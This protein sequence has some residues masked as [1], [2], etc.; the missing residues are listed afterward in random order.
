MRERL[1]Q[2]LRS[3]RVQLAL[4][5]ALVHAVLMVLF[6]AELVHSQQGFLHERHVQ[7]G[8]SLTQGMAR[9]SVSDLLSRDLAGLQ[10]I[11]EG[12]RTYPEM[13]Y[14][15]IVDMRGKVLA[16]SDPARA[17]SFLTDAVST[18]MLAGPV[19]SGVLVDD[20]EV[21]DVASP[22]QWQGRAIGWVRFAAG[23]EGVNAQLRKVTIEGIGFAGLSVA[24]GVVLAI[25]MSRSTTSRLYEL[26][27]V[28]AATSRGERHARAAADEGHEVGRLAAAFNG[29]LD[30]LASQER[31][32]LKTNEEL[33]R[34]VAQRTA[35]LARSEEAQR[36]ILEQANDAFVAIGVD[37]RVTAWNRAAE[38]MFGYTAA[39]ALGRPMAELIIPPRYREAHARGHSGFI[40]TGAG[41]VVNRR[42]EITGLHRDG[43]EVPIELSVSAIATPD[44]FI[45]NAFM[46]DIRERV[47]AQEAL[48]KSQSRLHQALE[49]LPALV[50][51][52]DRE[53]RCRYGNR[54]GRKL[55]DLAPGEEIGLHLRDAVGEAI[56]R[57]HEPHLPTVLA[58]EPARFEGSAR[59]KGKD[60]HF[61]VHLVPEKDPGDNQL[62]GFYVMTFDVTALKEAQ[63][64]QERARRQLRAITDNLPV[65]ISY[66]DAEH[67]LQFLNR[68][69]EEWTGV[70]VS[71]AL[72]KTLR[73]AVGEQL[74]EQRR[75]ALEQALRGER[76]L[77]EVVSNAL[78]VRRV[79]QTAYI[80]DCPSAE[81]TAGVYTLTSDVTALRDAE[82]KMAELALTDTLTGLANRRHFEQRLP[83]ALSRAARTRKGTAL[84]FLDVDHFKRINDSFGHAAGDAV[85][86]TFAQ[87]L[88]AC[89]RSTD[90]VARLAG[91]EFVVVLEGLNDIDECH[92]IA[93]KV[94]TAARGL[95]R[96]ESQNL[97][98][99]TSIGIAY[100]AGG[101]PCRA[102]VVLRHADEALYRTKERGRDGYTLVETGVEDARFETSAFADL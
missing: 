30:T 25:W 23:M 86:V 22:V 72:G 37:G 49:S 39:Q 67:R 18:R 84:M 81:V 55:R 31:Q 100:L 35:A 85:L 6:V 46:R 57:L 15:A 95:L 10:E 75:S 12:L 77:F 11:V 50:G 17:G 60:V 4:G 62:T 5:V 13:R 7:R 79:L 64:Q 61:H 38:S 69:F 48:K 97:Q 33:E 66:I 92:V 24:I 52:F 80:P 45:A 26:M 21:L 51:Y 76:V 73:E 43:H 99:T 82:R 68:T 96:Y 53:Q 47:A 102:D 94:N 44:G 74:Y 28:A 41:P 14:I 88:A 2:A 89:T 8:L 54:L 65:M 98:V 1:R 59:V 32:L 3:F 40:H 63:L 42:T 9:Q 91:D 29:M 83:E 90:L 27:R 58:G 71:D 101:R 78:G 20:G 16:H 93:N 87:R 56:Y 19:S 70:A 34:R 36:V